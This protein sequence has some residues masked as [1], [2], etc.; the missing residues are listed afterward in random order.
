MIESAVDLVLFNGRF[1]T[2]Q[3]PRPVITAA[4]AKK[5][6]PRREHA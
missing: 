1:T 3:G 2:L 4:I 6:S 5:A